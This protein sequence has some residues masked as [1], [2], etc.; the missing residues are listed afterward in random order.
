MRTNPLVTFLQKYQGELLKMSPATWR[1][2][3]DWL[4]ENPHLNEAVGGMQI[5]LQER[6]ESDLILVEGDRFKVKL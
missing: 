3:Q 6:M 2:V 1:K 5:E 4:D